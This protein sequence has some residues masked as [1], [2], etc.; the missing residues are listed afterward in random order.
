KH[1]NKNPAIQAMCKDPGCRK[2]LKC[3]LSPKDP[4]NCCPQPQPK[5]PKQTP[6]HIVPDS[7]FNFKGAGRLP[8]SSG[9][10]YNYDSAPCICVKGTSHSTGMH[11][12]VHTETNN[13]TVNHASVLPYVVGK[14]IS[15]DARW[16]VNDAESVGAKAVANKTKC[17][18][19]CIKSQTRRGHK[20]MGIERSDE[21]RPS[22]AGRVT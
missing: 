19:A 5:P 10:T 6:H 9:G 14:T 12:K 20:M 11:G 22:T 21:I 17:D 1:M 3:V 15:A 8:L 7:Q 16:K 18:E 2:A 13:L 4:S